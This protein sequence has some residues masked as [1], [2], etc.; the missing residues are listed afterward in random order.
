MRKEISINI[1][2]D[3]YINNSSPDYNY[4]D[5]EVLQLFAE[6]DFNIVNLESPV[7]KNLKNRIS[8]DGPNISGSSFT[9]NY[10]KQI[11]TNLVTLANN[12]ILDF[13]YQGL[14]DTIEECNNNSI[15][16]VG[17][18]LSL[19]QAK[20]PFIF[21][22]SDVKIAVLNFAENEFS[23]PNGSEYGAN[24][25]DI[26]ENIQQIREARKLFDIIMVIIHGGHEM[27][28]LPSPR[29]V[30]Q[31]RCYADSGASVI[32]GHHTHCI[33][34]YEIHH[35]VPIFYG[36]GNFLFTEKSADDSWYTGLI[37]KLKILATEELKWE[38]V[39][40]KQD[41]S[42]HKL[43]L[44]SGIEKEYVLSSIKEYSSI[45]SNRMELLKNWEGFVQ[46]KYDEVV[47]IFSPLQVMNNHHIIK[48]FQKSGL[49]FLF[50]RKSHYLRMLNHLRCESLSDLSKSVISKYLNDRE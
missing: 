22:I 16:F 28:H 8:K 32:V 19:D 21:T 18:G 31:Y 10:L 35:N 37:L 9:F 29:M 3:L 26:I 13:G 41:K 20:K 7:T 23:T 45:I 17:A 27:Y 4:F 11:K 14:S 40:I 43:H 6:S 39:P 12:H 46:Y 5:T 49:S 2:G 33:S 1:G 36:L 15:G 25:L 34:G 42:K 47:D 44:I 38:L 30:A 50:R 24:P 48:A